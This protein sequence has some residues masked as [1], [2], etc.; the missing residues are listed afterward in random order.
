MRAKLKKK[1]NNPRI[2]KKERNLLKGAIRRVFSRSE[3]RQK[4]V[5]ASIRPGH[6]DSTR[7]RVKKWSMCFL[8]DRLTP[9]YQV[10][11]DHVVPVI[12]LDSNLEHM[13][14]DSLVDRVWTEE[15]NLQAVCKS[16]HIKKTKEEQKLR[17]ANKRRR[18]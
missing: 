5:R 4:V 7:P 2:T 1:S 10:E 13:T 18:S 8:C 6:F 14:W 15:T 3:L 12:P 16:C 17:R 9:T 11:V